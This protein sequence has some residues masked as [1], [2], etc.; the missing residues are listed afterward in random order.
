[1]AD[2]PPAERR[3][4]RLRKYRRGGIAVKLPGWY[5]GRPSLFANPFRRER[6]GHARS[7]EIH[8]AWL[9]GRISAL[10]L[11]RLGFCP[12]EVDTLLRL[13]ARVRRALPH[14]R[15]LD[16][17]CWCPESSRWCHADTLLRLANAPAV[18]E[19]AA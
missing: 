3:P 9:E 13:R 8:R 18:K 2:E 17:I 1:M 7:V 10:G 14:L 16:L 5:V 6:F 19:L 4:R 12:A 11:E 15:G